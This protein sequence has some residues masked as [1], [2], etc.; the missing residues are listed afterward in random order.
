MKLKYSIIIP[1]YNTEKYIRKCLDSVKKQTYKNYEVIIINDGSTDNSLEIINE[2]TKDKRF[3]VYSIKNG[4][5][6]NAR[7]QG[8]KYVTGDYICFLDSDDYLNED[9]LLE[10]SKI[11]KKYDM[12]K[13][14]TNIVEEN[15]NLIRKENTSIENK[16][17]TLEEIQNLEFLE[18]AWIYAYK[19]DFFIKNKFK[20]EKGK[21]YEDYGLTPLCL[22]KANDIYI[23]DYYGYNY[24]QRQGSIISETSALKRVENQ[25]FHYNNLISKI[26]KDKTISEYK[27]ELTKSIL[28]ERL[29]YSLKY[30]PANQLNKYINQFT[31]MNVFK[32]IN[33]SKLKKIFMKYFP[34]FYSIVLKTKD[35]P[36]VKK[37]T[38][39][40]LLTIYLAINIIYM[41]RGSLLIRCSKATIDRIAFGYYNLLALNGAV[42]LGLIFK[43]KYKYKTIDIFLLLAV[44]LGCIATMFAFNRS[45]SIFGNGDRR[46]GLLQICYY[47]S[48]LILSSFLDKDKYKKLVLYVIIAIGFFQVEYGFLQIVYNSS[49]M[50]IETGHAGSAYGT[51]SNPNFYGTYMILCLLSLVGLFIDEKIKYKEVIYFILIMVFSSGLLISNALSSILAFIL[52]LIALVGY[53]ILKK[54]IVKPIL[55]VIAFIIP[56]ILLTKLDM[57]YAVKDLIQTK[58]EVVEISKGNVQ[59]NFG[60]DRMYL[61]KNTLKIVPDHIWNGVGI[62]NFAYAFD[63][64]ALP[65]TYTKEIIYDKAHNEYLQILVTQGIFA[66]ICWLIIYLLIVNEGMIYFFKENKTYLLLPVV[67]YLIQAFFNISVIEVAPVFYITL[68]FCINRKNGKILN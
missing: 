39:T 48:L 40:V 12:I 41:F 57:T 66:L 20:Y 52:V 50:G 67:G 5:L 9:L 54:K 8:L 24:V 18:P 14:K 11:D 10:L 17:V 36:V 30:L 27:K 59:D 35:S 45:V 51:I 19:K 1:V 34:T 25:I 3:K 28:A 29:V 26:E 7:N 2:Y 37:I 16:E 64:K 23:L 60:T 43:K 6:S 63:G 31:E 49:L 47:I 38:P 44:L 65:V 42:I 13:Y 21:L 56:L 55:L 15:G 33:N 22:A 58:D 68:G 62:D 61:W 53:L 4:G 46:E 32:N